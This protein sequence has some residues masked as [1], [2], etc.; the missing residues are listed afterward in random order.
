MRTA[1]LLL[2]MV[3]AAPAFAEMPIP[4][5]LNDHDEAW[6]TQTSDDTHAYALAGDG[7]STADAVLAYY[8]QSVPASSGIDGGSRQQNMLWKLNWN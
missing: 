6:P 1:P 2:A 4:D 5:D 7:H 8:E 3:A